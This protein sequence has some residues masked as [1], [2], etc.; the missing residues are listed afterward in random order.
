MGCWRQLITTLGHSGLQ[1][2][3]RSGWPWNN[4]RTVAGIKQWQVI[5]RIPQGQYLDFR[6]S[7]ALLEGLQCLALA[8]TGTQQM[9]QTIALH[10]TQLA[11]LSQHLETMPRFRSLRRNEGNTALTALCLLQSLTTEA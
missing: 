7:Q 1:L 9:A 6:D 2:G 4:H 5:R 11:H 8:H 10:H 3:M